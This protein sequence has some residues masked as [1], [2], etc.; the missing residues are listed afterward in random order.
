MA[1]KCFS[2]CFCTTSQQSQGPRV[3]GI[4]GTWKDGKSSLINGLMGITNSDPRAAIVDQSSENTTKRK[5]KVDEKTML[6][7]LPHT[8]RL[9]ETPKDYFKNHHL[10]EFG[11][12]V[13][14]TGELVRKKDIEIASIARQ[15]NIDCIF[16]RSACD[17]DLKPISD[18]AEEQKAKKQRLKQF[19]LEKYL[20][21]IEK[22]PTLQGV[23]CYFVSSCCFYENCNPRDKRAFGLDEDELK[24]KLLRP[25]A[26]GICGTWKGGKSS[27]INGIRGIANGDP[28]AAFVDP[29]LESTSE[30]GYGIDEK[31]IL[32]E[33]PHTDQLEETPKEYFRNH[34]LNQFNLLVFV[35]GQMVRREVTDLASIA[36]QRNIDC[37]FVRSACDKDLTPILYDS[38][39]QEAKKQRFKQ[40]GLKKYF[41]DIEKYSA[42]QGVKCYFVSSS[43]LYENCNPRDKLAFGLDEDELKEKVLGT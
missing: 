12:L 29:C 32:V 19:G 2:R 27:L 26:I 6:I 21:D 10:A 37:I 40:S 11:L 16:V 38:E 8:R 28:R 36:I 17:R 30:H 20:Q 23:K 22:Y 14:V 4:C 33:L 24:E 9:E 42:L 15:Y 1:W 35:T 39:E 43:C 31:T 18:N 25:R 7:E 3:I 5:Y 34:R 41:Q 13:F